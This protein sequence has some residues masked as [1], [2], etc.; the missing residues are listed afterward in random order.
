MLYFALFENGRPDLPF[1]PVTGYRI[2]H[3]YSDQ[4]D[5]C[6]IMPIALLVF[7]S[8]LDLVHDQYDLKEEGRKKKER[9]RERERTCYVLT[10]LVYKSTKG[11]LIHH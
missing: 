7:D 6:F 4:L 10:F 5:T 8:L 3:T 11:L 9:E 2:S 1:I